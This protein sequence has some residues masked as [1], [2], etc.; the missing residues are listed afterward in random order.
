MEVAAPREGVAVGLSLSADHEFMACAVPESANVPLWRLVRPSHDSGLSAEVAV[1]ASRCSR[2]RDTPR[3][4]RA[5]KR[6]RWDVDESGDAA[7]TIRQLVVSL[8]ERVLADELP[9]LPEARV[10]TEVDR[11]E[12]IDFALSSY[13]TIHPSSGFWEAAAAT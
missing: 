4:Y 3:P 10:D 13:G 8:V 1:Y 6:Y 12:D 11:A 2:W 7:G 5:A 9:E